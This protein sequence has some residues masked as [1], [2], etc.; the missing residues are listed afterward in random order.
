MEKKNVNILVINSNGPPSIWQQPR[1]CYNY[2]KLRS[3][4]PRTVK[5]RREK[6][7]L[8]VAVVYRKWERPEQSSKCWQGNSNKRRLTFTL[9][10]SEKLQ[11]PLPFSVQ[12]KNHAQI[13]PF[14]NIYIRRF[15]WIW[16]PLLCFGVA[17]VCGLSFLFT[18]IWRLAASRCRN[19]KSCDNKYFNGE[20]I[21]IQ[22][23]IKRWNEGDS[24]TVFGQ[25]CS[26]KISTDALTSK[27]DDRYIV[28]RPN[29]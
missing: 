20:L 11:A 26:P 10:M 16:H 3:K 7:N 14:V 2:K 15:G 4:L 9:T 19:S 23:L 8:E 29:R 13:I 12:N 6:C 17:K 1:K 25:C 28:T 18:L 5:R 21:A 27:H 22:G 24:N